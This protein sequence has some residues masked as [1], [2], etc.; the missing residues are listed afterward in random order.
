VEYLVIDLGTLSNTHKRIYET[1]VHFLKMYGR[2][3]TIL[4]AAKATGISR[5]TVYAWQKQDTLDFAARF[6]LAKEEY[7]ESLENL[8]MSRLK[9]PR[10]NQGSDLLLMA[11]L[12][13][14]WPERYWQNSESK[15]ERAKEA[16]N[17]IQDMHR[18]WKK[19]LQL[20]ERIVEGELVKGS[21]G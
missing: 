5:P 11:M 7:R 10:G 13:A 14:R 16:L 17:E 2:S 3:G 20:E 19:K 15:N 21:D 4:D 6:Q 1:Q 12:N 18:E 8:A 9:D